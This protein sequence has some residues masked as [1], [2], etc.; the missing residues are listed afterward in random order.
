MP[1]ATLYRVKTPH[2]NCLRLRMLPRFNAQ[3]IGFITDRTE[4]QIQYVKDGWGF[5]IYEGNPG[6]VYM[7]YLKKKLV[8]N[9]F[10]RKENSDV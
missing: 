7:R 5:T 9:I 6:W 2:K 1:K 8:L 4:L 3:V 10:N